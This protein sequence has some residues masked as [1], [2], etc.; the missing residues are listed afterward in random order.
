MKAKISYRRWATLVLRAPSPHVDDVGYLTGGEA[1]MEVSLLGI[2]YEIIDN[3]LISLISLFSYLLFYPIF[4][5]VS[6]GWGLIWRKIGWGPW[7]LHENWLMVGMLT[8][9]LTVILLI[10]ILVLFREAKEVLRF[11]IKGPFRISVMKKR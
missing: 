8:I 2:L 1:K 4:L 6:I 11:V 5:A 3:S 7:W 9:P 10:T